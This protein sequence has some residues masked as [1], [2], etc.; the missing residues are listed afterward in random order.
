MKAKINSA[1]PEIVSQE[2]WLN[3]RK[4]LLKKEKELTRERDKLNAMRRH[5]PMIRI[6]KEYAF[7]GPEGNASLPDLFNGRRQL[8]IH[9]FMYFEES[10]SFCHGCS[11]EADQNYNT[12]FLAIMNDHDLTIAAVSKAPVDRIE[13]EKEQKGWDFPFYS[14][15]GSSFNYDFQATIDQAR[16]T[17]YNYRGYE[18]LDAIGGYEGDLPGRSIFLHDGENVYHTYSAY[19]R[20]LDLL[21]THYNYLDMTPYGRQE[22]WED[23]PR[24]WPQ[25]TTYG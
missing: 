20:G 17:Q 24:G 14:S 22:H 1:L 5:L 13:K 7:E 9:H 19:T 6:E 11:L 10:D 21:A 12:H 4:E 3:K 25:K 15:R 16:N 2:E 8:M 23:S 18:N